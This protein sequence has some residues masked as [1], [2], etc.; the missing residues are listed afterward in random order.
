MW[1]K[2]DGRPELLHARKTGKIKRYDQIQIAKKN[3]EQ[4]YHDLGV[5]EKDHVA[6]MAERILLIPASQGV[7]ERGMMNTVYGAMVVRPKQRCSLEAPRK[8]FGGIERTPSRSAP[9]LP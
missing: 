5:S 8:Q 9:T 3:L 6:Y 2:K 4:Y 1:P 7:Y